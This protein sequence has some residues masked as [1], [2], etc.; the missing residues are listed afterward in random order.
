MIYPIKN[1]NFDVH[2]TLSFL[3]IK[4]QNLTQNTTTSFG[5]GFRKFEAVYD[6]ASDLNDGSDEAFGLVAA[7]TGANPDPVSQ[8]K[9]FNGAGSLLSTGLSLTH[10][11]DQT[12]EILVSDS[13][14]CTAKLN[15]TLLEAGTHGSYADMTFDDGE[16]VVPF[17][18]LDPVAS[19]VLT[20]KEL[21]F[22]LQAHRN[23]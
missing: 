19:C 3:K 2:S 13:G 7:K 18:Q 12:I 5:V 8:L 9:R 10:A 23:A 1:Q 11:A 20:I 6:K 15:G 22:G 17:I 16:E 4:F 14:V 21:E